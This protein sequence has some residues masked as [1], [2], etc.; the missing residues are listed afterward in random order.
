MAVGTRRAAGQ[1]VPQT[2]ADLFGCS[3]HPTQPSLGFTDSGPK[4]KK[5]SSKW[6]LLG[7][8]C[9]AD[10]RGQRLKRVNW[11]EDIENGSIQVS[12]E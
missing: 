7:E 5:I 10:G 8:K 9:L 6:K 4:S 12:A 3:P 11:L 2:A 1:G